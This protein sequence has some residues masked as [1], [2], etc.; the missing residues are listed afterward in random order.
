MTASMSMYTNLLSRYVLYSLPK[1]KKKK[2]TAIQKRLYRD[3]S[4]W[5]RGRTAGKKENAILESAGT[6]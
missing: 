5:K 1:K 6:L 2:E 4:L 3:L